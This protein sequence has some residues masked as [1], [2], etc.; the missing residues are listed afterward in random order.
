VATSLDDVAHELYG[1][2][3]EEF[4]ATRNARAKEAKAA[5]DATLAS[6]VQSLRKPTTGAW[7]LNRLVRVHG[8]EVEQVLALGAQLRA[9]QGT[10]GADELRALDR[11]RRQLTHAVAQQ[12][13]ALGRD[14]GHRVSEQVVSEVEETLRSAMVDADAG[15]ALSTGLLTDT[16]SATGIDAVDLSAVLAVGAPGSAPR[17]SSRPNRSAGGRDAGGRQHA[18]A[19]TDGHAPAQERKEARERAAARERELSAA[20]AELAEAEGVL[21]QSRAFVQRAHVEATRAR[22]AREEL[23]RERD[24]ARRRLAELDERLA[25]GAEAQDAA[26]HVQEQ[27][28]AREASAQEDVEAR[29]EHLDVLERAPADDDAPSGD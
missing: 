14:A 25:A 10:V 21:R 28:A 13:R 3:P 1:L 4:T 12:A 23:A 6:A 16:F 24:E 15:A 2:P 5:G 19:P 22:Q 27:A 29:R 18:T 9:A 8:G 20:R 11:Q 17:G 26:T 7:L